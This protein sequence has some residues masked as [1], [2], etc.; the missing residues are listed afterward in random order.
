LSVELSLSHN[1]LNGTL[2]TELSRLTN[3]GMFR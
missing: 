2:D 1:A 3:L